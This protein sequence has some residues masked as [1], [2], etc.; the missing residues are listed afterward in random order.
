[1][2]PEHDARAQR[3][4]IMTKQLI[5]VMTLALA[6]SAMTVSAQDQDQP[7]PPRAPRFQQGEGEGSPDGPREGV[8]GFHRGPGPEGQPQDGQRQ[9][10]GPQQ[11]GQPQDGQRPPVPLFIAALDV[12]HD[13]V[14]DEKEIANAA[15]A[16]KKLDKNKDG[17]ITM[18]ELRPPRPANFQGGSPQSGNPGFGGPAGPGQP[19]VPRNNYQP[20]DGGDRPVRRGPPPGDQ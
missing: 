20:Q 11:G 9:F 16:L 14:I 6:L 13:G 18:D 17:K 1:M 7:R 15:K 4:I 5:P 12:N 8:P 19:H 10:R 3:K 2:K